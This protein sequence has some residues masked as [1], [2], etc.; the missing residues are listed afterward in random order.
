MCDLQVSRTVLFQDTVQIKVHKLIQS[1]L[2]HGHTVHVFNKN[3]SNVI[4]DE[5]PKKGSD[6][7]LH[8]DIS[9][10]AAC[11]LEHSLQ[12]HQPRKNDLKQV[13]DMFGA[14]FDNLD[15]HQIEQVFTL[16]QLTN[17]HL[18]R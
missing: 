11:T 12:F 8:R 14:E 1:V 4:G 18:C 13:W 7:D 15:E 5:K 16:A 17:H 2:V 3:S 10:S 6:D 9:Y